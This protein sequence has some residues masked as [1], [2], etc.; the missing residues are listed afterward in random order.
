MPQDN[1]AAVALGAVHRIIVPENVLWRVRVLIRVD[2]PIAADNLQCQLARLDLAVLAVAEA[3]EARGAPIG[4][5]LPALRAAVSLGQVVVGQ[6]RRQD[7][8]G[9]LHYGVNSV[10][11]QRSQLRVRILNVPVGVVEPGIE[12]PPFEVGPVP[13]RG[14]TVGGAIAAR[15]GPR[16]GERR[17]G[18]PRPRAE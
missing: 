2:S 10:V 11:E 14:A 13:L 16:S 12:T 9:A 6:G 5:Q 8:G 3:P 7:G 15:A 18:T 17:H 1:V 4:I